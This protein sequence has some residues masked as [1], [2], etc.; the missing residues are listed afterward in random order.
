MPNEWPRRDQ[1]RRGGYV[2]VRDTEQGGLGP[3]SVGAAPERA[4]RGNAT[5]PKRADERVA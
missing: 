3:G 1:G 5:L 4:L 2:I